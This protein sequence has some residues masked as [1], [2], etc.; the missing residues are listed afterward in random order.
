MCWCSGQVKL[1]RHDSRLVAV[2]QRLE[3][4]GATLN[5]A[6]C[7]FDKTSLKFL[8]HIIDREGI[9]ADPDKTSAISKKEAPQSVIDL[10]RFMGLVN[11]LG[12]FSPRLA[13]ISQPLRE[14]LHSRRVW[15]WSPDQERSF[16]EIKQE[17]VK[18][19]VLALYNPQAET[20]VSADASS[21]GM[22][23]VLLQ[24]DGQTWK[25]VAYA[26]RALS[27]TEKRYAQIEKEA[28]ATTRA[29]EK[30][31]TYILGRSFLIESDH[32]PLIPLL[33]T[34]HL[35][36]LP[37]RILRFQLRLAKYEY[38]A[39]HVPGKLLYVADTLS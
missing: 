15:T 26:S 12:K 38:K 8:G 14:L 24:Q 6:K 7:E 39:N 3:T 2:L 27:D 36:D 5:V 17:L 18:P 35:D 37:P 16:S 11:Q 29:C 13:E 22:G 30:F 21:F 20:K 1:S 10:R 25:P 4:A 34:K 32:K 28:L 9:R 31:S 19:T 33:N 23:A